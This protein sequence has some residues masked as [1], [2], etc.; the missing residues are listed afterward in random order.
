LVAQLEQ[1]NQTDAKPKVSA[2]ETGAAQLEAHAGYEGF[3]NVKKAMSPSYDMGLTNVSFHDTA[4]V[5]SIHAST[6]DARPEGTPD[7]L[8]QRATVQTGAMDGKLI[9]GKQP[10]IIEPKDQS[11][12]K[13]PVIK[14]API[15]PDDR[16]MDENGHRS[17]DSTGP[18]PDLPTDHVQTVVGANGKPKSV[19]ATEKFEDGEAK[20][21]F[22]FDN[23]GNVVSRT[24]ESPDGKD[25]VRFD[26]TGKPISHK[27]TKSGS[28]VAETAKVN[29]NDKVT[30]QRDAS[31][32]S[33]IVSVE[34]DTT[35]KFS[36]DAKGNVTSRSIKSDTQEI[37][38]KFDS[39]GHAVY[40]QTTTYD[41][42]GKKTKT[43]TITPEAT[44]DETFDK[45]GKVVKT[46]EWGGQ[47]DYHT[48]NETLQDGSTVSR[49]ESGSTYSMVVNRPDGTRIEYMRDERTE[50]TAK[51]ITNPD[52][53]NS[54]TFKS[55]DGTTAYKTDANGFWDA[56]TVKPGGVATR[57]SG[58]PGQ[59]PLD[60]FLSGT[61]SRPV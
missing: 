8:V 29:P 19:V 39:H 24:I 2:G 34:G 3:S 49:M 28:S 12:Y 16:P 44:T 5:K 35:T 25:V 42:D 22:G 56:I 9:P 26:S 61:V 1:I 36:L 54:G 60:T 7:V 59:D 50:T 30:V 45:S 43:S 33:T 14:E 13:T 15:G 57:Y 58:A 6:P 48:I 23:K 41:S 52:G 55:P 51:K 20:T 47:G 31:G 46:E 32:K 27:I 10:G 18:N 21:T 38:T 37:D 4:A 53:S 11:K 40:D 17:G